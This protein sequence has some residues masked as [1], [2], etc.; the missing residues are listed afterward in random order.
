M[1][2]IQSRSASG[3]R[4]QN[5]VPFEERDK[6]GRNSGIKIPDQVQFRELEYNIELILIPFKERD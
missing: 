6:S 1:M 2:G 3:I 4:I 5:A